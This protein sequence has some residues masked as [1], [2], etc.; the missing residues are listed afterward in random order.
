MQQMALVVGTDGSPQA[1]ARVRAAAQVA[2]ERSVSLHVVCSVQ[3][4]STVAQRDL[5]AGLPGDV[6]HLAGPQGQRNAAI[7]DVHD[8]LT[9]HAAGVDTHVSVSPLRLVK[10][11][12]TI[13]ARTG[14]RV[15]GTPTSSRTW[16]LLPRLRA[17][18]A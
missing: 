6:T 9:R 15:Y 2:R 3:P 8:L 11:E 14:G 5:D 7:A 13:A 10:A 18:T 17:R 16:R 4:L 1:E 12:R